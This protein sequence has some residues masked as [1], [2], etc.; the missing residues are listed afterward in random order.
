M[1]NENIT[2]LE[3]VKQP[4]VVKPR[5]PIENGE[6]SQSKPFH[7]LLDWFTSNEKDNKYR[8]LYE[9]SKGRIK[10]NQ[11]ADE[12]KLCGDGKYQGNLK[13]T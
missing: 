9:D 10:W 7:W 2:S 3:N 12:R 1:P 5:T 8:S 11:C 6:S 13:I 4:D